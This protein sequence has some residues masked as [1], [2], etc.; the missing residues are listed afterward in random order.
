MP[1]SAMIGTPEPLAARAA[2]DDRG[3]LRHS[4]AGHDARGADRAGPDADFESVNAKRD[5]IARAFGCCDVSGD[6]LHFRQADA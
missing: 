1:P 6:E 3:D 5:Q 2:F 4:G